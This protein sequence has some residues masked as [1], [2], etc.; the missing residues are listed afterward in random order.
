MGKTNH[1]NPFTPVS[2]TTDILRL[3]LCLTPDDFIRTTGN[4]SE[5][6]ELN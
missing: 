3:L 2:A 4:P 6:K 5:V 1:I